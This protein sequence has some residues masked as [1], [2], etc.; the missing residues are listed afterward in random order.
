M[1]RLRVDKNFM[2]KGGL[3]GPVERGCWEAGMNMILLKGAVE[4]L[5]EMVRTEDK[6]SKA[7]Q[8]AMQSYVELKTSHDQAQKDL[9]YVGL[10]LAVV[11]DRLT[12]EV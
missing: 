8:L 3:S 2:G 10:A 7:Y 4:S 5:L 11:Q 12:G 6:S 1:V 9:D